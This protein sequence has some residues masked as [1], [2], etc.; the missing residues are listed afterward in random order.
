M[1]T[2]EKINENGNKITPSE[3]LDVTGENTVI[4][5]E[6]QVAFDPD[7]DIL[8]GMYDAGQTQVT[9]NDLIVS[10]FNVKRVTGAYTFS[11]GKFKLSRL[12]L[13]SPYTLEKT[14]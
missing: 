3:N 14:N 12:L 7:E 10:G 2:E 1:V 13:L 4:V 8:Q 5:E 9:T 11:I 6:V